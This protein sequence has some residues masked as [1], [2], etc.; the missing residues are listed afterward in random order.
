VIG[1]HGYGVGVPRTFFRVFQAMRFHREL[2]LN[3]AFPVLPYHGPRKVGRWHGEGLGSGDVM[4]FIHAEAQAMWDIRRL[5]TWIRAQGAAAIGLGGLSLGGYNAALL[6]SLEDGFA[7]A[8]A[9]LPTADFLR[10][11]LRH[12]PPLA[13]RYASQQGLTLKTVQEAMKVVSPLALAPRIARERRYIFGA[14]S[15]RLVSPDQVRDLW[16]HWDKPPILWYQGAH[17]TYNWHPEVAAFVGDA[18]RKSGLVRR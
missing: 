18:M 1:I 6:A 2:G 3:L 15:D 11:T 12:A 17:L 4:D 9:G 5:L 10:Q 8:V 16:L 14:V 7:C 13:L